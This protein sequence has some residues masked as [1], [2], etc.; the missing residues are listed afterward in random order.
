MI[1]NKLKRIDPSLI[2]FMSFHGK[3]A[4]SPKVLANKIHELDP[5][6]QI[7]WLL[8]DPSKTTL[9]KDFKK[10]K[11]G[12]K[13]A[14]DYYARAAAVVDNVYCNHEYYTNGD[15]LVSK[16]R[17]KIGSF[18]RYKKGQKYYTTWHGTPIKKIGA[19]SVRN[20]SFNF[21]C[22]NTTLFVDNRFTAEVMNRITKNELE[23]KLM[24]EP[25]NDVL[26][27]NTIDI[28]KLK[29][30]IGLPKNKKAVLY[31]PTFRSNQNETK[32]IERSGINQLNEL[33]IAEILRCLE[34]T[35]GDEWVFIA[36]FHY[37]VERAIDWDHLN[38]KY[39]GR[40]INGNQH[41][42]IMDYLKCCDALITDVSSCVFDFS[43][44]NK[45]AFL[46]FPDYNDYLYDERG[47]YFTKNSLPWSLAQ[48]PDE[49]YK[50]INTFELNRYV[51][52][53][54]K[55]YSLLGFTKNEKA[56]DEIARLIVNELHSEKGDT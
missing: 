51:E 32:N 54:N 2:V 16:L 46:Y 45:P 30:K 6:L 50:N 11:L 36:R 27:D 53:I 25:R 39:K 55:F 42:D 41:D 33:N 29:E 40:V 3:Y 1:R 10:A 13:E 8:S 15:S 19:D 37:H 14:N 56:A 43:L 20:K 24:G 7:V 4:D 23:I 52:D 28:K 47:M 9:P 49:L 5:N 44:L 22:P 21:S 17:F 12:T 35:F 34:K 38:T 18:L 48:K 31:A 26:F